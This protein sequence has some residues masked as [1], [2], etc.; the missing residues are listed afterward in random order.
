MF[1]YRYVV[2]CIVVESSKID[3]HIHIVSWFLIV[4]SRQ[5]RVGKKNSSING[6]A[7]ARQTHGENESGSIRHTVQ[8]SKDK[9]QT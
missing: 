3:P 6:A 7:T 4:E 5:F 8:Q 2:H 9:A 1:A